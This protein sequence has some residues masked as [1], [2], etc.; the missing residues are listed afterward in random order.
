M[1]RTEIGVT[2]ELW[3]AQD[4]NAL[5]NPDIL[6]Q[7]DL[8]EC[9]CTTQYGLSPMNPGGGLAVRPLQRDDY[10]RGYAGVLKQLTRVGDL[11]KERYEAQFDAMKSCG[12]VHYVVVVEDMAAGVIVGSASLIVERKFIHNAA[13]RGRIEDV[14]VDKEYRGRHLATLL[15]DLV[16]KL[17]EYLGCYKTSLD[18][19]P[20]LES[21]YGRFSY[22]KEEPIYMIQRFYD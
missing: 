19:K 4:D 14:V 15:L 17:S 7:V 21:F 9:V 8:S 12:G 22:K 1:E 2:A 6:R 20:A 10:D 13:L 5:F 11:T 18:C 16:T 3:P